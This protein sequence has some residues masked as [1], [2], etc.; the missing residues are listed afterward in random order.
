MQHTGGTGPKRH[1]RF[2]PTLITAGVSGIVFLALLAGLLAGWWDKWDAKTTEAFGNMETDV[3]T[4][5]FTLLSKL[6]STTAFVLLLA[7]AAA[8]LLLKKKFKE[9]GLLL[10][11]TGGSYG[12]NSLIKNAIER[13]RPPLPHLI[14][15][16][17]FSFPSGNAMVATAFY[18]MIAM[19]ILH[20]DARYKRLYVGGIVL[21]LLLIGFSRLY[22]H[23]HYPTDIAAGYTAGACWMLGCSLFLSRRS[24]AG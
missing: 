17:G 1:T 6:G 21:V 4:P 20:S 14:E 10:I 7:A 11:S 23:V 19:L 24:N 3:L 15:A 18:G 5:A 2:K 8:V 9:I 13:E 22:L 16:D 12:L